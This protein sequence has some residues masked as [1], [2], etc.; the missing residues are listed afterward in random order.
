[1]NYRH[2]YHAGNFADVLKHTALVA[3]LQ[4]LC[5]K[6]A[7][8]AVIDSHAGRGLYDLAGVEAGKTGE[9]EGGILKLKTMSP[10]PAA[11]AAYVASVSQFGAQNYPGSPVIAARHL[12]ERDR[13]IAIEKHEEE[14]LA[15]KQN[16]SSTRGA[17]AVK[18]DG[19]RE[20]EKLLPPPE[21]RGLVLI[22]PPFEEEDEFEIATQALIAA[23]RRFAN[24]IYMFWYPAKNRGRLT[25]AIGELLNANIAELLQIELDI[26][27]SIEDIPN[28]RGP[29]LTA[30]G[31]LVINPPYGFTAA[32]REAVDYLATHLA[33]GPGAAASVEI[34]A[35]EG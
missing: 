25:R 14:F 22:D 30:T 21:R 23:N 19:Y 1:M 15:L 33:Q 13:L 18:N 2:A 34:L 24:G 7:P 8:F 26:G 16:L 32:M 29:P 31:L 3:V 10:L 11:L 12:R 6:P 27:A 4:H 28:D 5:K 9:A 17:R 35:G 20:L